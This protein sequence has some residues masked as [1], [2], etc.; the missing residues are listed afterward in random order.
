MNSQIILCGNSHSFSSELTI[1]KNLHFYFPP[2]QTNT[3]T[4]TNTQHTH[5]QH[6]NTQ[7]T[8][9]TMKRFPTNKSTNKIYMVTP[10]KNRCFTCRVLGSPENDT[11]MSLSEVRT[12]M[13]TLKLLANNWGFYLF[14]NVLK[15]F[16]KIL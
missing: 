1:F 4:H 12:P 16:F 15:F 9:A 8:N 5:T 10:Y 6:T 13:K 3:Q 14:S 7:H 11:R 2:Q